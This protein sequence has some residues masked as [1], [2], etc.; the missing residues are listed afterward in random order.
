MLSHGK[1][2]LQA[3]DEA[4]IYHPGLLSI[5]FCHALCI[6]GVEMEFFL[7]INLRC[8]VEHFLIGL[9]FGLG[10]ASLVQLMSHVVRKTVVLGHL[11]RLTQL[12]V[13]SKIMV[14]HMAV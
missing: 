13:V 5:R 7:T 14:L 4:C 12:S 6:A 1:K 2:I 8:G 11:N 3:F 10:M 9:A